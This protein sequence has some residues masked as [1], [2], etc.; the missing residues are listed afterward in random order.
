MKKTFAFIKPC[1]QARGDAESMKHDI[2]QAGFS[3]ES[4]TVLVLSR[5]DAEWLYRE[6]AAKEHFRDLVDFTISGEVTLMILST[7]SEDT[8]SRFR[9]LMGPSDI[10]K[11]SEGTLRH[12]YAETIR[13]N[14]IH[15]SDGNESASAELAYFMEKFS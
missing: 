8:P 15:G 4:E 6:H 13:R 9:E 1:A 7:D 12:K 11:A 14:G 3:I 10:S 5:E 2:R